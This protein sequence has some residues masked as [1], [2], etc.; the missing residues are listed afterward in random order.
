MNLAHRKSA[1]PVHGSGEGSLD[2]LDVGQTARLRF[3]MHQD[4]TSVGCK[5]NIWKRF[6]ASLGLP[7]PL[8]IGA[9]HGRVQFG[10]DVASWRIVHLE[11]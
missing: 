9:G 1:F 4:A 7:S 5:H 3:K 11:R 10:H 8:Q 2:F 6:P